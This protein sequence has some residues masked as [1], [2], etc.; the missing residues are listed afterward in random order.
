MTE[1]AG[2]VDLNGVSTY[3]EVHGSGEPLLLLHGWTMSSEMWTDYISEFS[4]EFR[5]FAVDLYGHGRSSPLSGTFSIHQTVDQLLQLMDHLK[6]DTAKVVGWSYGGETL[7]RACVKHSDRFSS[8]IIIGASHQF[9]KQDW[10]M[11]YEEMSPETR[12][13]LSR[14]HVHGEEQI[15]QIFEQIKNYE[16]ILTKTELERISTKI[17]VMVGEQDHFVKPEI[18]V[19]L[20]NSLPNAHMWIVPHAG[21][22]AFKGDM[23][24]EFIRVARE[25]LTGA[26]DE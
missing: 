2:T 20:H 16:S 19:D 17:L 7:L 5:V 12:D 4:N 6:I 22:M 3:Y 24:P 11:K 15:Y 18:A 1:S 26:W 21:H 10:G 14:I 9:P 23:K 25:F 8:A 13:H